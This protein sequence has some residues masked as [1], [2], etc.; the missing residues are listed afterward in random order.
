LN[1]DVEMARIALNVSFQ[2]TSPS[3]SRALKSNNN[4]G[5]TTQPRKFRLYLN[6]NISGKTPRAIGAHF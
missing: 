3:K 4:I 6:S 2:P 5:D 1:Q